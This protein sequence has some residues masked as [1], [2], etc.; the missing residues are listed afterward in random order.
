M[1]NCALSQLE[2]LK[3]LESNPARA[4]NEFP[5][6]G[7]NDVPVNIMLE[8]SQGDYTAQTNGHDVYFG[9]DF[10]EVNTAM[11]VDLDA[12][13]LVGIGDLNVLS[14]WWLD[15]PPADLSFSPNLGGG[16]IVNLTDFTILAGEWGKQSFYKGRQTDLIFARIAKCRHNLLL[17][18]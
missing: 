2:I 12:D 7:A 6:D 15:T 9:T 3:L 17:A 13:G 14:Q 5:V 8:W 4:W 18:S 1:Y 16:P 10:E 11:P